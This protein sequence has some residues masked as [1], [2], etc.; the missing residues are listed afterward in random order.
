G[1][2]HTLDPTIKP[3]WVESVG[4]NYGI[5]QKLNMIKELNIGAWVNDSYV[6]QAFKEH[7]IDYDKQLA[8]FDTYNVK[9]TDPVCN[10]PVDNPAQ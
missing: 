5:L 8:S 6:R 7:G 2:V 1:G 10:V 9:G 4:T 3:K